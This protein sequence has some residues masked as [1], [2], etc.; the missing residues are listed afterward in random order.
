MMGA[1]SQRMNTERVKGSFSCSH[2]LQPKPCCI[3]STTNIRRNCKN[4]TCTVGLPFVGIELTKILIEDAMLVVRCLRIIPTS[5]PTVTL[6]SLQL[7]L[8]GTFKIYLRWFFVCC[9]V[10]NCSERTIILSGIVSLRI[11][12]G[13]I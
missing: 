10:L 2:F 13:T 5:L 12:R 8:A 11:V 4:T 3:S 9:H 1:L 7:A 6:L